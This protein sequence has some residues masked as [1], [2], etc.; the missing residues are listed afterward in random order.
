MSVLIAVL[1]PIYMGLA[2]VG[3]GSVLIRLF[4][5]GGNVRSGAEKISLGFTV[6]AGFWGWLL[7]F[8][9]ILGWLSPE[10]L[11]VLAAPGVVILC[12]SRDFWRAG[13]PLGLFSGENNRHAAFSVLLLI[14]V[15]L[16]DLLE[17]VSPPADGDTL[18]YHA[19]IPKYFAEIGGIEFLP[20]AVTGAIPLLTHLIYTSAY[21]MGGE[22]AL[23]LWLMISGWATALLVY[24]FAARHVSN[25]A[26][27]VL[28]VLFLT[29]PAILFSGGNGHVEVRAAGYVLAACI[30]LADSRQSGALKNFALVGMLAGCFIATKYF[31]LVFAASLGL[32]ILLYLRR[33]GPAV[34]YSAFAVLIGFQWYLWNYVHTG[35]PILPSLFTL[36]GAPD[37][38]Y[39]TAEFSKSFAAYYSD[40]EK[41]LQ[42]T[43]GNWL[44]YPAYATF[45]ALPELEST[46]TGFGLLSVMIL[47]L[48]IWGATKKRVWTDDRF[49][50]LVVAALFFTIWFFSGTTHRA[51]HLVP[52]FPLVLIAVYLFAHEI[53]VEKALARPFWAAVS[54]ALLIQLSGQFVFS[55]NYAKYVLTGE[56]RKAFL[57]RNVTGANS[58]FWINQNVPSGSKVAYFNRELAYLLDLPSFFMTAYYQIQ[59]EWRPK[60][61]RPKLFVQQVEKNGITHFI[62]R[63]P[64]QINAG[65]GP[66]LGNFR[67]LQNLMNAGCLQKMKTFDTTVIPSRTLSVF[68]KK[69]GVEQMTLYRLRPENCPR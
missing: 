13:T 26:S 4:D 33:I 46:R 62:L 60:H 22:L 47:P 14:A 10:V 45:S 27:I 19:A 43:I 63:P 42:T 69:G 51:R 12:L 3:Y 24:A 23:T 7:F 61:V 37:G 54:L 20:T 66:E 8:P 6:G 40:S 52:V 1:T 49:M 68:G 58:V 41:V 2:S 59:V 29:T 25:N 64:E 35:D 16:M 48:A 5:S 44:L 39:W 11:W 53:V 17:G 55:A 34:V 28:A 18:A 50:F 36:I 67:M 30:F 56:S 15:L 31:G 32:V 38:L 65:R 9:G 57:E 21:I